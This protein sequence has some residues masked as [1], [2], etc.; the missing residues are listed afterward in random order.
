MN[1]M[2]DIEQSVWLIERVAIFVVGSVPFE[3]GGCVLILL[4]ATVLLVTVVM[5]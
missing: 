3:I 2:V 4:V 5:V 1:N